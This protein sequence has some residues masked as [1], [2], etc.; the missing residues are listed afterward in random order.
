MISCSC[1]FRGK[2]IDGMPATGT[3]TTSLASTATGTS[4]EA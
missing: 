1:S 2:L 3:Q 4:S